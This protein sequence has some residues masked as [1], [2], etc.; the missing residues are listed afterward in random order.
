ME[1]SSYDVEIVESGDDE[2]SES[3][4]NS[5]SER[6]QQL[7]ETELSQVNDEIDF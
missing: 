2:V 6:N 7:I 4:Q 3:D 1:D 5:E